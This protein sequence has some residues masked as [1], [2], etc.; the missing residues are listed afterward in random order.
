[1][2]PGGPGGML[3]LRM[4]IGKRSRQSPGRSGPQETRAGISPARVSGFC[5]AVSYAAAYGIAG[6]ADAAGR[7]SGGTRLATPVSIA[8]R[9][10]AVRTC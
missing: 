8:A 3:L 10:T 6:S 4:S 7:N 5:G 9:M 2:F 1:M